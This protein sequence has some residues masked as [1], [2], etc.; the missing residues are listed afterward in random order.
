MGSMRGFYR[1]WIG[2]LT[3]KTSESV[4]GKKPA[5]V[6]SFFTLPQLSDGC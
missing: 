5:R 3:R 6:A 2:S 4:I 1:G